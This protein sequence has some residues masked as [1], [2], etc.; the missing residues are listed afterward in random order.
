[1]VGVGIIAPILPIYAENL[2]ATGLW[3]GVIFSGYAI[4]RMFLL[5]FIG[6]FSDRRGRKLNY[7]DICHYQ[8]IT[9]ALGETIKQMAQVDKAIETN[10]GWPMG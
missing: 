10:G 5:P 9:I 4:S 7:E 2:G 1:M 3:V 6:R 8:K